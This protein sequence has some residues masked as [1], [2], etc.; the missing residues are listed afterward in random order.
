MEEHTEK[1][2]KTKPRQR[3][4]AGEKGY[5]VSPLPQ[6]QEISD[7]LIFYSAGFSPSLSLPCCLLS[8]SVHRRQCPVPVVIFIPK[9]E[10][11]VDCKYLA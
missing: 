4:T 9:W 2:F 1:Q 10:Q 3:Y 8:L 5:A 7:L 6:G 11:E